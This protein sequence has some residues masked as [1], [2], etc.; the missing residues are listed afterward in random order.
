MNKCNYYDELVKPCYKRLFS[1]TVLQK[2]SNYA[3]KQY[4]Y[5]SYKR[6]LF[7]L[8]KCISEYFSFSL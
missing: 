3:V 6:H 2:V 5:K 8:V 1:K 7:K 4:K